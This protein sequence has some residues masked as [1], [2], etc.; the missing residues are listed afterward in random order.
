MKRYDLTQPEDELKIYSF[1]PQENGLFSVTSTIIEAE[2]EIMLVDAQFQKYDAQFLVDTI[3][4]TGKPLK[5]IYISHFD[6]DFYFGLSII[7]SAFPNAKVVA[8]PTTVEGIKRNLI[9]KIEYWQPILKE[10]NNAPRM[11]M[12]PDVYHEDN[13]RVGKHRIDIKGIARDPMRTYLWS[14]ET[15]VLFG[16][17]WL[18]QG[19]HLWIASNPTK[20]SREQWIDI[21]GDMAALQPKAVAPAHFLGAICPTVIEFN[22][23]YLLRLEE[24][25][26]QAQDSQDLIQRMKSAYPELRG[27]TYLEIGATVVTGEVEWL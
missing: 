22:K 15:K 3:K 13:F 17:A 10:R 5:T 20:K 26:A 1:N 25:L 11:F 2:N 4:A 21:L 7:A 24:E 12:I 23:Q 18:F 27:D 9:G 14:E 16:G 6:P 19:I 8:R